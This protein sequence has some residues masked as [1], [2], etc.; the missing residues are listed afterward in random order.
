MAHPSYRQLAMKLRY[1]ITE[2]SWAPGEQLPSM[3]QLG[4]QFRVSSTTV[5]R[6]IAILTA[7]GLVHTEQG[8]G[9]YISG[10]KNNHRRGRDVEAH[11]RNK[12]EYLEDLGDV[13]Y[14]ACTLQTS[15]AT[16]R[17]VLR[18]L[19]AE[20]LLRSNNGRYVRAD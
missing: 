17:R 2:D 16:V 20:G 7:E 9:T 19:V 3:R 6:A 12:A 10:D 18:K 8:K 14:L 11:I 1:E 15:D 4:E 5:R 13:T